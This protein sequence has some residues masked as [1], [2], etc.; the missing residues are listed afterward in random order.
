MLLKILK[1]QVDINSSFW[2]LFKN[3]KMLPFYYQSFPIV[4]NFEE[5]LYIVIMATE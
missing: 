2:E 5:S 4:W 3:E 1:Q